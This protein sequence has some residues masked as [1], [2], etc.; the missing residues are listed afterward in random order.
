MFE[1]ETRPPLPKSGPAVGDEKTLSQTLTRGLASAHLI[2]RSSCSSRPSPP[3]ARRS[4]TPAGRTWW[5]QSRVPWCLGWLQITKTAGKVFHS[6][7]SLPAP[8]EKSS[9]DFSNAFDFMLWL[10]ILL[11]YKEIKSCMFW[12]CLMTLEPIN[13]KA[14]CGFFSCFKPNLVHFS[15]ITNNWS[16]KKEKTPQGFFISDGWGQ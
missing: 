10:W 14:P 6:E 1:A 8:A 3:A 13:V 2:W 15:I 12:S 16:Q 7:G 9:R 4:K 11:I 5:F